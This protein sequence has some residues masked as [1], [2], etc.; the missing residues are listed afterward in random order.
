MI[1]LV[2]V[3]Y[4]FTL[5][6]LTS[7]TTQPRYAQSQ[8]FQHKGLGT[9]MFPTDVRVMGRWMDLGNKGVDEWGKGEFVGHGGWVN[10]RFG[11]LPMGG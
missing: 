10:E 11:G 9:Q 7:L 4:L 6:R 2:M 8:S 3:C 5:T 1:A